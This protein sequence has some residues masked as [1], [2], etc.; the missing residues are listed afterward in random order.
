M[1]LL[2]WENLPC[3]SFDGVS[4]SA[5]EFITDLSAADNSQDTELQAFINHI[6]EEGI[7]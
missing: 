7:C 3:D 4:P 2:N 6:T 5:L 1:A